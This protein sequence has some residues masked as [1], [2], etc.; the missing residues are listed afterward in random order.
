MTALLDWGDVFAGDPAPDRAIA[1]LGDAAWRARLLEG[2]DAGLR[3]RAAGWAV[4]FAVVLAMA[5]ENGA[6]PGFQPIVHRWSRGVLAADG[7]LD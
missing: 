3:A 2:C 5:V 1:L 6:G 4:Y 7:A